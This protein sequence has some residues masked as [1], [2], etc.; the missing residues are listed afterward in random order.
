MFDA[1][2]FTLTVIDFTPKVE[3]TMG[4]L[5]KK[6]G[7][8]LWANKGRTS[9]VVL[10]IAVGAF[11]IGMIIGSRDFMIVG[12]Q[13][14]WRTS[15]PAMIR[16]W[17][18]PSIDEDALTALRHVVGI[19]DVEGMVQIAV[20]W[21]ATP[22]DRWQAAGLT[23]R[24]DYTQQRFSTFNLLSG[25]WPHKKVIGVG[26]GADTVFGLRLGSRIQMRVADHEYLMEIGG[27]VYD[28]N[29]QPPSFGGAAQFYTTRDRL[30]EL[31]GEEGF[32]RILAS[33]AYYD[34]EWVTAL[35][36]AVQEKLE[37]QGV[38]SGGFAPNGQRVI[39]PNKHFFQ[40]TMDGI[41]FI[42][43]LLAALA[44][45]LGLLLV[46]NTVTALISRQTNQ[47][48]ILKA[49]G[50]TTPRIFRLYLT[51]VAAYGLLALLLALPLSALGARLLGDFLLNSFNAEG[52]F[53]MSPLATLV[54]VLLA[55]F[56]PLLA[57]LSPILAGARITVREAISNQG[58][59]TTATL[60][61]RLLVRLR[62]LPRLL[63]LT[64]SNTFRHKQRVLL[65]QITLV[66]SGLI[67]MTVMSARDAT[68]Y[69][70]DKLLF[71]IMRFNIN[72]QLEEPERIG[73]IEELTRSQP[74]VQAVELWALEG[75]TLRRAG[76]PESNA[77]ERV[78]LFG[79]P[80]PTQLYSP[81]LRRG[82]WLAPGDGQVVV[83]NQVLAEDADIQVG[84]WVTLNFG[85]QGESD[86]QVVGLIFDP[87]ITRS[88]HAPRKPLLTKLHQTARADTI[89]IQTVEGDPASERAI[90]TA[91]RELYRKN[92]VKLSA[93]AV[94][95]YE[96]ASQIVASILS[97]FG[98]IITLLATMAVVIG[99]VGSIALSGVLGLNVLERRREIGVMRA[100]GASTRAIAGLFVGEGLIL[101]W[102]SWL[103]SLP[104]SIPAGQ[105][106]VAGLGVALGG[107]LV[108]HYTPVG[109]LIWLGIVTLLAAAASWL[110]ARAAS[111]VS[112]R[113]SLAYE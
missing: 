47:I 35:A 10:I 79:L 24:A 20:E 13:E 94:F 38:E 17:S 3:H 23:A 102:L 2:R 6:I 41:F 90:A 50:A 83:L 18:N 14:S 82:R 53:T 34:E 63:V 48:G 104:L 56:S 113:E 95:N 73:R 57:C 88:A 81:Q 61:D 112:V 101:G 75:A 21:R 11:A 19:H 46:Y 89:W 8:E 45:A 100:I 5:W 65:T 74:G 31:T 78:T 22:N 72:F 49:I 58:L 84:D 27:V 30:A 42:M 4:V 64:I 44:L 80:L 1:L 111:R 54:Q 52:V 59:R 28:P 12:M 86:W 92:K 29:V 93:A 26:Q 103:L 32:N 98:I 71:S 97:Q 69:T 37:R 39:D 66:L 15:N 76:R 77:D 85:V 51:Q 68:A 25:E 16:L 91:L 33:A 109:G 110:P 105:L 36:D 43:G 87:I 108:Y 106:M 67:F 107:E 7:R 60:L 70:F 96:T 62:H 9:Q 40:D 99:V 55:L